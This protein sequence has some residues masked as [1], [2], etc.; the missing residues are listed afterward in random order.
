[1]ALS[2]VQIAVLAGAGFVILGSVILN[3]CLLL[4]RRNDAAALK[5][6]NDDLKQTKISLDEEKIKLG[7]EKAAQLSKPIMSLDELR[8]EKNKQDVVVENLETEKE[9]LEK[10]IKAIHIPNTDMD[11]LKNQ[12]QTLK[13]ERERL[14][15][16][17]NEKQNELNFL[18]AEIKDLSQKETGLQKEIDEK[19][20]AANNP[21]LDQLKIQHKTLVDKNTELDSKINPLN[22]EIKAI[23]ENLERIRLE[24]S[25]LRSKPL[26]TSAFENTE[27]EIRALH[28][29]ISK[30]Q[31]TK[32]DL[33][34]KLTQ[35]SSQLKSLQEA[36]NKIY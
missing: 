14:E 26:D 11:N 16:I 27:S 3:L 22:Q 34:E 6:E 9:N 23:N 35:S 24:N 29:E 18:T 28:E 21:L 36:K 5:S 13:D 33:E 7:A 4:S 19:E 17:L 20:K 1:M 8:E 12:S 2:K 10:M 30:A 25:E 32:N 15:K 31:T